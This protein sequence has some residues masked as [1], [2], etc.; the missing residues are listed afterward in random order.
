MISLLEFVSFHCSTMPHV[1]ILLG[2]VYYLL[3]AGRATATAD[4]V[5]RPTNLNHTHSKKISAGCEHDLAS[6][7]L[8]YYFTMTYLFC[9]V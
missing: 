4:S 9:L 3:Q 5:G 8:V 2:A 1:C 6:R 7:V